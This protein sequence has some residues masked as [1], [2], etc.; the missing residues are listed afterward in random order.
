M[1][2]YKASIGHRKRWKR[3]NFVGEV[4]NDSK[5]CSLATLK[6]PDYDKS[7]KKKAPPVSNNHGFN[8]SSSMNTLTQMQRIDLFMAGVSQ[9]V[10]YSDKLRDSS[11]EVRSS[12]GN[13]IVIQ[14]SKEEICLQWRNAIKSTIDN[15]TNKFVC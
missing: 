11:L 14:C 7:D 5:H 2:H 3:N 8:R 9:Y 1:R 13:Q 4:C 12:D 6:P 10:S 15:L